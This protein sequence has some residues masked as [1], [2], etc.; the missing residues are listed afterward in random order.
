[1]KLISSDTVNTAGIEEASGSDAYGCICLCPNIGPDN[2]DIYTW[3]A[4]SCA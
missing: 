3:T 1:M 2:A 4:V